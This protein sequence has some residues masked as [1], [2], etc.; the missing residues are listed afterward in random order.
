MATHTY[1]A[2]TRE[3]LQK[4]S[5]EHKLRVISQLP[6][7]EQASS[8]SN[9]TLRHIIVYRLL[10]KGPETDFLKVFNI[11]HREACPHCLPDGPS[12][13][14]L[15]SRQVQNLLEI[16]PFVLLKTERELLQS[17]GGFFLVALAQASHADVSNAPRTQPERERLAVKWPDYANSLEAIVGS[18]S[19]TRPSSSSDYELEP[20]HMDEDENETHR[21]IPEVIAVNLAVNFLR[22]VLQ[23]CLK[24]DDVEEEIRARTRSMRGQATVAGVKNITFEDDAGISR[25]TRIADGWRLAHP[26]LALIEAKRA[27]DIRID[28]RTGRSSPVVSNDTIAQY[29]GEA[30]LAWRANRDLLG[31]KLVSLC[32][33]NGPTYRFADEF[34][35]VFLIAISN[36]FIRFIHFSFGADYDE[37]LDA[38]TKADQKRLVEN[39]K[40]DTF[41]RMH[42]TKWF[43]LRM[44][45]GRE[46]AMCHVLMLVWWHA[47]QGADVVVSD[48]EM[49][50]LSSDETMHSDD[51]D[52]YDDYDDD[53]HD[54]DDDDYEYNAGSSSE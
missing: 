53:G 32:Y 33:C 47:N 29:L 38:T 42:R 9:W 27:K 1:S 25:Y 19:P 23:L 51:N 26:Y 12:S 31:R 22:Y 36:T 41:V 46:I 39:K 18:S 50:D 34:T 15:D 30:V 54:D 48:A 6:E 37:Y 35:S 5:S 52:E 2:Q 24:Q 20:G 11:E 21:T 45:E 28:P 3:D 40:K 7:H 17:P 8:A 10:I 13:L 44:S 16:K 4:L 14:E 49:S 43:D